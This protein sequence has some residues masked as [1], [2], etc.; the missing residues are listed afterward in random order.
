MIKT[1]T[2]YNQY[3]VFGLLCF[4]V[5]GVFFAITQH[6][7]DCDGSAIFRVSPRTNSQSAPILINLGCNLTCFSPVQS[8]D[9]LGWGSHFLRVLSHIAKKTVG[10][11][12]P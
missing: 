12:C 8:F 10:E 2:K 11:A 1:D 7:S 3:V 9:L 6:F 4:C 5:V